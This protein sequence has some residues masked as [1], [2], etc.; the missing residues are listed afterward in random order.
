MPEQQTSSLTAKSRRFKEV[1]DGI[2]KLPTPDSHVDNEDGTK[3]MVY[4][5]KRNEKKG[6]EEKQKEKGRLKKYNSRK[7]G[8]TLN[9]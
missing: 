9:H 4:N 8:R 7:K 5:K 1:W 3:T 6:K 2:G